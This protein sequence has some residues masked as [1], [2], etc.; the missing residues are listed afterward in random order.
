M[1]ASLEVLNQ[2]RSF[3]G[4][5]TEIN[6]DAIFQQRLTTPPPP[7]AR[8]LPISQPTTTR[9]TRQPPRTQPLS[10][11]LQTLRANRQP[12]TQSRATNQRTQQQP[13]QPPQPLTFAPSLQ[14]P[15]VS[16]QPR[17]QPTTLITT[18]AFNRRQD[19]LNTIDPSRLPL[20][21]RDGGYSLQELRAFA[22]QLQI[23]TSGNRATI[24]DRLREAVG[25]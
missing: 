4:E 5:I 23:P 11:T 12:S 1:S 14:V 19:A 21:A 24:V 15:R 17:A 25:V 8:A 18:T 6:G 20:S 22:R 13:Q 16:A 9:S 7:R 10:T 2:L 3:R